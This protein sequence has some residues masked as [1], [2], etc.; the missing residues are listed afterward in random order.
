[1]YVFMY[2]YSIIKFSKS[3][4]FTLLRLIYSIKHFRSH[5]IPVVF[6]LF[7]CD[8]KVVMT[9][10][11]VMAVEVGVLQPQIQVI[12][13]FIVIIVFTIRYRFARYFAL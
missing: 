1:M 2:F 12:L 8:V 13:K 11:A 9:T 3:I 4:V 10:F 7:G 5:E 6:D